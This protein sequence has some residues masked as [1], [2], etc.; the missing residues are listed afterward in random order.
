MDSESNPELL[1]SSNRFIF[2]ENARNGLRNDIALET[3][4]IEQALVIHDVNP[5]SPFEDWV[6]FLG[7]GAGYANIYLKHR[8]PTEDPIHEGF[9]MCELQH[10]LAT[11][12]YLSPQLAGQREEIT[13]YVEAFL[14]REVS[15]VPYDISHYEVAKFLC[16]VDGASIVHA[17]YASGAIADSSSRV[18]ESSI[19]DQR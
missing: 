2:Y 9:N 17:H 14:A 6:E 5:H 15:D 4:L 18:D 13:A 11:F 1:T 10:A 19:Y 12:F 7:Y 8:A 16:F 3:K